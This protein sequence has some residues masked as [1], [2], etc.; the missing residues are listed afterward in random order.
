MLVTK[1][2]WQYHDKKT[3]LGPL[4]E[5][6]RFVANSAIR[7]GI[8]RNITSQ[9]NLR[10]SVYYELRSDF[11]CKYVYGAVQCAA[12][13]LKRFRKAKKKNLT[14][15]IPHIHKNHLILD[16][17]SYKLFDGRIRIPIRPYQ[18]CTIILNHYVL[19]RLENV[20]LGSIT[21]TENKLI[22]SYSRQI[23]SQEPSDFVGLDRNL[24]NVTAFDTQNKLT[25]Y[26]LQKI[27]EIKQCY[28][29]VKSKFKRNDNRI[30]KKIFKKYGRKQK[31]KVNHIL[32][33]VTKN[34]VNQ[35]MGLILEDLK[36]IRKLYRK[37]NGQGANYRSKLNS[38][39]F[40]ELQR[41]IEYKARW[42]GLPV[43]Y[44][45]A[46]GTSSKCAECGSKMVPEEHRKLFCACCMT[47]IDR[48]VN[49]AKN[50]LVRGTKVVPIGIAS[51]AMRGNMGN[52]QSSE[53][54]P[55]SDVVGIQCNRPELEI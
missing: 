45:T 25:I 42:L 54:M 13:A 37:G 3:E 40:Y 14:A 44:V 7:M 33:V 27:N 9:F 47:V 52:H 35:N 20:K 29:H 2:V 36:G 1:C 50:I 30:K 16:N 8:E 6:F 31:D 49:A 23:K 15:K 11:H 51:E 55:F 46:S 18:Y 39:S 22:I 5:Y 28:R 17:D 12:S 38:W 10:P 48:D 21:I 26:D 34:T 4:F 53:S 19:K 24:D 43:R 32:H 41:Q